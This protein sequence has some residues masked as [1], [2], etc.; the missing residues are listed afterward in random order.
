MAADAPI[1]L[2]EWLREG[3][4]SLALSQGFCCFPALAGALLGLLL[5][6]GAPPDCRHEGGRTALM[7]AANE[8]RLDLCTALLDAG[9]SAACTDGRGMTP[10][11]AACVDLA[12]AVEREEASLAAEC[13]A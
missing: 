4:F 13:T 2:R 6:S 3:P 5:E 11:H 7:L 12:L 1:T 8:G 10:L 9:A